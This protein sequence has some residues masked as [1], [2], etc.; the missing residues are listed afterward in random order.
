MKKEMFRVLYGST[1]GYG[2]KIAPNKW[3]IKTINGFFE[4]LESELT[5]FNKLKIKEFP[6]E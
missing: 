1:I 2:H 5:I 4:V 3:K 6:N